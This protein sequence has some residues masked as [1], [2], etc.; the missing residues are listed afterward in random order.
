MNTLEIK[1]TGFL[2][3]LLPY[4]PST[5]K[6]GDLRKGLKEYS[7]LLVAMEQT[8]AALKM[9]DFEQFDA[10][11][12]ENACQIRSV[13]IA[14]IAQKCLNSV[15]P[16]LS[17]I[18]DAKRTIEGLRLEP[19]MKRGISLE[20]LLKEEKLDVALSFD[21]LFLIESF[22]LSVAKTVETAKPEFPLFRN[23][24][25]APNKLERF[26][27]DVTTTYKKQLVKR[28]RQLLSKASVTF[29]QEQARSLNDRQLERMCSDEFVF[30]YD[31][32]LPCIP[33][34]WTYKTLLL[35]A[36]E[37]GIPI[38]IYAKFLAKDQ[39]NKVVDEECIFFK[40]KGV[41][42]YEAFTPDE[43]DLEK[44]A[45]VV[46]G[47]LCANTADLPTKDQWRQEFTAQKPDDVI[48]AGAADHRQYPDAAEDRRIEALGDKE[49]ESYKEM[50]SSKG[51]TEKNPTMFFIQHVYPA[52][53][54]SITGKE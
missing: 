13:K 34:F 5:K 38:V 1:P 39:E 17:K 10:V 28:V 46:Q 18:N 14:M 48:L 20:G 4:D 51:Y 15:E 54:R 31:N 40:P 41:K 9:G 29:V 36:R 53:V 3:E 7:L 30:N 23:D 33:M 2:S 47:I 37:Q 22:L 19:L 6:G 25:A 21:E 12:G 45:I 42:A 26:Q 50:A 32:W 52:V 49:F 43:A 27:I 16:I 35:S 8:I 24:A 11:V 44:V